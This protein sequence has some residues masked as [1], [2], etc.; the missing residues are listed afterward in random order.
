MAV[1]L[2]KIYLFTALL[3]IISYIRST[4]IRM[5][6]GNEDGLE[7]FGSLLVHTVL[8]SVATLTFYTPVFISDLIN[9]ITMGY[10]LFFEFDIDY[11]IS[12]L[13][14]SLS[15]LFMMGMGIC[16]K[17]LLVSGFIS[18]FLEDVLE[19]VLEQLNN[20]HVTKI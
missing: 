13:T 9:L 17:N 15:P 14:K 12:T 4:I 18:F 7:Y 1:F 19:Y 5:L 6:D 20:I 2:S 10:D 11:S 3:T 16:T 8:G